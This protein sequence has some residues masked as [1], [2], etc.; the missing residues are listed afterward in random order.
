MYPLVARR[1]AYRCEYCHAPEAPS[2]YAFEVEHILP[3]VQGGSDTPENLALSCRAC[4]LAKHIRTTAVDPVT[5]RSAPLFNP[6]LHEWDEHFRWSASYVSIFGRTDVGRATATALRFNA[7][8]RQIAR[9][10]WRELG[11]IP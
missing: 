6:R 4:N 8:R 1:A 5:R 11:L 9:A 7:R 3:R 10:L 2:A